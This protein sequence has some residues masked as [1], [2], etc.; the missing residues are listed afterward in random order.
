MSFGVR[1]GWSRLQLHARIPLFQLAR[2]P[3]EEIQ[4]AYIPYYDQL[5]MFQIVASQIFL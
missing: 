1:I 4:P 2:I 3:F 5:Q